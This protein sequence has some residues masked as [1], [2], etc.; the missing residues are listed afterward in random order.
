MARANDRLSFSAVLPNLQI[1]WDSVSLGVA[2]TCW[3]KY[4]LQIVDGWQ[5]KHM[6]H[7]LRY[8]QL[9]HRAGEVY[10]HKIAQGLD[11]EQALRAAL[12]DLRDGCV[13]G[14]WMGEPC[15]HCKGSGQVD[16]EH[17]HAACGACAGTGERYEKARWWNPH[18]HLS[19]EKAKLDPKTVPNLFR[20]VI[21]YL[22]QYGAK[23]PVKVVMLPPNLLD[24]VE[25][26]LYP[27]GKPAVE[28]SFRYELGH[29]FSTGE[30]LLHSG[31]LDKLGLLGSLAYVVDKKTSKY[32]INGN[33]A[34]GY[35][36]KFNPDN[37]MTG[38]TYAAKVLYEV[39][40]HG[41]IID[42]AQIAK[43]FSRF[44]RGFTLRTDAQLDEW[45][46]DVIWYVRQAEQNVLL[47]HWPMNDTACDNYGGCALRGICSK[48]PSVREAYL[49]SDFTK[50]P[51][52]PLKVRGDI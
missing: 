8:G 6:S 11:H 39:K 10:D 26:Q 16:T 5:P 18:E 23:D 12:W 4:K 14:G 21:W 3:R 29:T 48:D 46:N 25:R 35:F 32:T 45:R 49:K 24:E 30:E 13:D 1:A 27:N 38:Y 44:E 41:V 20:T 22:D 51:W 33:S 47:D 34:W 36:A 37:Q 43:G 2:K 15:P 31:H 19:E 28:L 9:Y 40:V 7:H 17:S 52:D 42:A 50:Q